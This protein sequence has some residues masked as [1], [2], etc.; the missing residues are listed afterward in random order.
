MFSWLNKQGVQSERGFILQRTGRFTAEYREGN[1]VVTL[2]VEA[3][4]SAGIPCLILH[5]DAFM[6]W[7]DGTV[8]PSTQQAEKFCNVES[9]LE[10]QNLK[11]VVQAAE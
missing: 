2:D 8:I 9:A 3:G 11:M 1:R 7:D 6:R 10:F 5:P 4:I